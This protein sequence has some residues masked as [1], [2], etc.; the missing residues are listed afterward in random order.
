[1]RQVPTRLLNALALFIVYLLI[2]LVALARPYLPI[3]ETRYV[4]V[5]WE[6]WQ[7]H[8]FLVPHMNG[9]LYPDKPPLL[10]W[11][12]QLG[13]KLFGVN[14]AWPKL[15][16][17]LA[18]LLAHL[19]LFRIARRLGDSDYAWKAT[20]ILAAML[21]WLTY[22]GV[23]MFDVLLT[24]CVLGAIV[25]LVSFDSLPPRS[26]WLGA[27]VWLGLALLAK[28]PAALVAWLVIVLAAPYWRGQVTFAWWKGAG[29]ALGLAV[30]MLLAWALSAAWVGGEAFARQL[31]WGQTADRLVE[32]MDH[33]RPWYWYLLLLP[34]LLFPAW[35]WPPLWPRLRL[36]DRAVRL[37]GCWALGTLVLFMLISG[38]QIHYLM[39]LLPALALLGARGLSRQLPAPLPRLWG[40]G[41]GWALLAIAGLLL[42]IAGKPLLR[43]GIDPIGALLLLALAIGSLFLRLR[44]PVAMLRGM[45][46]FNA[47]AWVMA[48]HVMLGPLWSAYDIS[49][50]SRVIADWQADGK[51]VTIAGFDY[52]ATFGFVGRLT[53]PLQ[54]I[55]EEDVQAWS[56]R[57]PDGLIVTTTKDASAT[58]VDARA[59]RYRGRWLV[60]RE[61]RH[62]L[63]PSPAARRAKEPVDEAVRSGCS[64]PRPCDSPMQHLQYRDIAT[65]G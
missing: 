43:E 37:L 22:S 47:L 23:V 52:Q 53:T 62:Y 4:S 65:T 21:L 35:T 3:D 34:V 16:A 24:A 63:S 59:F 30:L 46:L 33:A 49:A 44:S 17:P 10:F 5:A 8:Q 15:I 40:M 51:A 2:A 31:F 13:W 58:P 56:Q 12:I 32:A 25:P 20:L 39:P 41:V 45:V 57:H 38:K 26:R 42:D 7:Q 55:D 1:M 28:G 60:L 18:A 11:L 48:V 50:P 6:M 27:G 64:S 61:A 14:D 9:A 54:E 19:Q 36:H 29:L